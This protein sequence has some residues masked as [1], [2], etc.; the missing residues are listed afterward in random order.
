MEALSNVLYVTSEQHKTATPSRLK[1][2]R[3]NFQKIQEKLKEFSPFSDDNTLRN[4]INGVVADKNVN[5]DDCFK[6]GSAL[7]NKKMEHQSIFKFSFKRS[8]KVKNLSTDAV[9]TKNDIIID[10]SL[11]FQRFLV[12]SNSTPI[13]INEVVKFEVCSYPPAIFESLEV[14]R[15]ANKPQITE[16][17]V[18]MISKSNGSE[19]IANN[20]RQQ[21]DQYVLDGGSLLHR[22][23]WLKNVPYK[24]IIKS[25][26][27]FVLKNYKSAIVVFDGYKEQPSTKDVTHFRRNKKPVSKQI[28]F[29][30][31]ISMFLMGD[32]YY[33]ELNG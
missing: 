9:S 18:K 8:D 5:V 1:R 25:Y 24:D 16:E 20:S 26:C 14:L 21:I 4:I 2:D 27:D 22:V 10:P 28:N 7:I 12:V 3:E 29:S 33:I 31:L 11:L 15:K 6:I 13:K 23:K 30:K 32:R 19:D 17:I